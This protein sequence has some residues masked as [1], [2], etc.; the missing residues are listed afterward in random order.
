M[1][2]AHFSESAKWQLTACMELIRQ[3]VSECGLR[4]SVAPTRILSFAV[5]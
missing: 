2:T 3:L 4:A 5:T 1:V